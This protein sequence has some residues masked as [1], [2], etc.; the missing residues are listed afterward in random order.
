MWSEDCAISS[1]GFR[2][3][4]LPIYAEIDQA[5]QVVD[6]RAALGFAEAFRL[7]FTIMFR[8]QGCEHLDALDTPDI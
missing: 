7:K 8:L 6:D 4:G 1:I 3:H 5:G 2:A